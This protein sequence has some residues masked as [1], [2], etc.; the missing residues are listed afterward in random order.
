MSITGNISVTGTTT[1]NVNANALTGSTLSS[2]VLVSS[3]TSV[4]SLTSLTVSGNASA[5]NASITNDLSVG[6]NLSVT[7]NIITV[8]T[9]TLL[10]EDSVVK[11]NSG[12]TG[13]PTQDAFVTVERGTSDDVSIKW[14]ETTDT[15]QIT[16]DGT[17]YANIQASITAGAGLSKASNTLNIITASSDRIV[18]NAGDI[19][20]ASVAQTNTS[21]SSG[22]SFVQSH[23]VDSYG[24]VTGTVTSNVRDATTAAKGIA[25]FSSD[26]F[27]VTDGVVTIKATGVDNSQLVNASM[28]IN[29]TEVTLGSSGTVAA[30][31]NTL[32]GTTLPV[33]VVDSSLTSVGTLTTGTWNA[34]TIAISYG[35]TGGTTASEAI[36]N[37][38]PDQT[39]NTGK[40][41]RSNGS[42]AYWSVISLDDLND[43]T[44]N[45]NNAGDFLRFISGQW[46]NSTA[47]I[48]DLSDVT[49]TSA[50]SDQYL[51]YNG[52]AWVNSTVDTAPNAN[53]TFT[54]TVTADAISANTLV[55]NQTA[56]VG[57]NLNVSGHANVTGNLTVSNSVVV[58]GDLTVSGTTTTINTATL[59]IA[60]NVITLNSDVT[61]GSPTENAGVEV[62]RGSSATVSMRWN[63]TSDLWEITEDGTNYDVFSKTIQFNQQTASYTFVRSDRSK[64]I[65]INNAAGTTVT[66]PPNSSVAFPVGTEIRV[67][68]TGAGQVTIAA[69][70]GVTVNATPGLKLRAQWSSVNI[71]KRATDTWV[72]LGDLSA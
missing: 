39:G 55:L 58:S 28:T 11:L 50:S 27:A 6:G 29:G 52:T 56:N 4:G 61:S 51:V 23:S 24:R 60:D 5:N 59:S 21:G 49:I 19:D 30:N 40:A 38:L 3:L 65:E 71:V 8:N 47:A 66:V 14:N 22:I 18:V 37:L 41:L 48:D 33:T 44:A 64:L 32:T 42:A 17:T 25:S 53:P 45:S 70:A 72:A 54:G 46:Q 43:V 34:S 10:V 63:E 2:N 69:G 68:Q 57:T 12:E 9:S 62:L 16:N 26:D 15:W 13:S 1:A 35:G 7:G 31:A 67:L 36:N 20:L